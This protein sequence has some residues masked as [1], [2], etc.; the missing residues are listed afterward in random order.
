MLSISRVVAFLVGCAAFGLAPYAALA[1]SPWVVNTS[2]DGTLVATLTLDHV[3][4]RNPN[5]VAVFTIGFGTKNMC[6]GEIGTA[7]LTGNG[8]GQPIGRVDASRTDVMRVRVDTNDEWQVHPFLMKYENGWEA[9]FN[10][11]DA[12]LAQLRSGSIAY[13]RIT[14]EAPTI[15]F[16]LTGASSAIGEAQT[17]CHSRMR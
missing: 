13:S 3:S 14:A 9:L 11:T 10:A 17:T 2:D 12:L 15:E 8:Y 7:L 5:I 4:Q 1:A 16:P 6:H